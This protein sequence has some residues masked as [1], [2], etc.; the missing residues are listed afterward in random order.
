MDHG[1]RI[2][3][4]AADVITVASPKSFV[5]GIWIELRYPCRTRI[6][7]NLISDTCG[8]K[9]AEVATQEVLFISMTIPIRVACSDPDVTTR[10]ES[11]DRKRRVLVA[12]RMVSYVPCAPLACLYAAI[13]LALKTRPSTFM[14]VSTVRTD[15]LGLA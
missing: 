1:E 6:S 13:R 5:D 11:R 8:L 15:L 10:S 14:Y 9:L 12:S 3:D 4:G 2:R 7:V